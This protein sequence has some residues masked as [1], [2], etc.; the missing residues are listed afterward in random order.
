MNIFSKILDGVFG[1]LFDFIDNKIP[2]KKDAERIKALLE[3]FRISSNYKTAELQTQLILKEM[4]GN[5]LQ[6]SWRGIVMIILAV[7]VVLY[8]RTDLVGVLLKGLAGF[9]G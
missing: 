3:Q 6:R 5:W 7:A 4:E 2:D 1:P 9:V 8:D